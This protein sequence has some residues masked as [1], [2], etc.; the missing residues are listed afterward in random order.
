MAC[1]LSI[2]ATSMASF[3]DFLIFSAKSPVFGMARDILGNAQGV[4][5]GSE[6]GVAVGGARW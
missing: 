2:H 1:R 6:R 5:G 4:A 3:N